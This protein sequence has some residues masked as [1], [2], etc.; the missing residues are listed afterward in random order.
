MQGKRMMRI[1]NYSALAG[2]MGTLS[3]AACQSI[4]VDFSVFTGLIMWWLIWKLKRCCI[5][6][7]I[8]NRYEKA[9]R[10]I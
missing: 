2:L 4:V 7:P 8:N 10:Q 1:F 9:M 6:Q 3:M 5:N